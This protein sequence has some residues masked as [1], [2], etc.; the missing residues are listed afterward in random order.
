MNP[1]TQGT[2]KNQL[3]ARLSGLPIPGGLRGLNLF[4]NPPDCFC[5]P[6]QPPVQWVLVQKRRKC[7]HSPSTSAEAKNVWSYKSIPPASLRDVDTEHFT[8]LC[9]TKALRTFCTCNSHLVLRCRI[10]GMW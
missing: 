8:F 5:C 1:S 9:T 2:T 6:S 10:H 7:D 4:Q 3:W